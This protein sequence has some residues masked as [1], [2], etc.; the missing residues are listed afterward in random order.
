MVRPNGRTLRATW[1]LPSLSWLALC[2]WED[3]SFLRGVP[4]EFKGPTSW[5]KGSWE[6]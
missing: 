5:N 4:G 6:E 1:A 2:L 3:T